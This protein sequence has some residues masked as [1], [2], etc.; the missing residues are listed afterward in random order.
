MPV[1]VVSGS[2]SEHDVG[3]RATVRDVYVGMGIDTPMLAA[4]RRLE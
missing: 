1:V 4:V 3:I 2:P